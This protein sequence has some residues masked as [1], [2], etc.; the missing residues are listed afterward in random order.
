MNR[1]E[2]PE[3][4]ATLTAWA[5]KDRP[6]KNTAHKPM[7]QP[8]R[9]KERFGLR[10]RCSAILNPLDPRSVLSY[11]LILLDIRDIFCIML[12]MFIIKCYQLCQEK[13]FCKKEICN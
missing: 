2:L 11:S 10:D 13:N 1:R 5:E 9:W 12:L 6:A 3:G 4:S 7:I 8:V